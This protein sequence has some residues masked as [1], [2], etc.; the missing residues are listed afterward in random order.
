MRVVRAW[1]DSPPQG[2]PYVSDAWPRVPVDN[3]NYAG[4]ASLG[5]DVIT[6][7]WDIAVDLADLERFAARARR[8]PQ[9]PLV[10]PCRLYCDGAA[11][12]PG[13]P[14][15]NARVYEAGGR[16]LRYVAE[17]EPVCHLFGFGMTYLPAVLLGR[18]LRDYPGG[19]LDD[20]SFSGWQY[21]TSGLTELDWSV[22]PVHLH[23]PVPPG[24]V[25]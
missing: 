8:D 9:V 24:G 21:R 17:G 20:T 18:F 16:S 5:D 22:Y 13:G 25:L 11:P 6:L 2:R 23:Y 14:L 1:P 19:P 7:D 3:Y 12:I 15:W 4:L 10:A